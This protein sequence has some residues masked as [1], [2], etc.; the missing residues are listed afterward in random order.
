MTHQA[1]QRPFGYDEFT[2]TVRTALLDSV[3]MACSRSVDHSKGT[4]SF[5]KLLLQLDKNSEEHEQLKGW[6]FANKGLLESLKQ[7]RDDFVA[8]SASHKAQPEK[9]ISPDL[10]RIT[11]SLEEELYQLGSIIQQADYAFDED[12]RAIQRETAAVMEILWNAWQAE[13]QL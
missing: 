9:P 10:E 13:S 5:P 12:S 2:Q 4:L 8:H 3:I 11:T 6:L 1:F 7:V